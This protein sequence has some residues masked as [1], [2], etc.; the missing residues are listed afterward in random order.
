MLSCTAQVKH[1]TVVFFRIMNYNWKWNPS[2][3]LAWCV[4][5]RIELI[6]SQE[7][8]RIMNQ[9]YQM[10]TTILYLLEHIHIFVDLH[11]QNFILWKEIPVS[12]DIDEA[13]VKTEDISGDQICGKLAVR[14]LSL[15]AVL[16]GW[17]IVGYIFHC[18]RYVLC[19]HSCFALS[20]T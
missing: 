13:A 1:K 19:Y 9:N 11:W 7:M 10:P 12:E 14:G 17:P 2:L 20:S 5:N 3:Q 4:W 16:A 18:M 6:L 8:R 15:A